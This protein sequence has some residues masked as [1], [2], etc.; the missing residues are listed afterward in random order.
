MRPA[1]GE[2]SA[3]LADL[4]RDLHQHPDLS[5]AETRTAAI[6]GARLKAAGFETT[7]RVGRTGVVGLLRNGDGPTALLRADMDALP[8]R[9]KTGL[10]YASD[11]RG[12]DHLGHEVDVFH[13]CGHDV[14]VTCLVGAARQLA[15]DRAAWAGTLMT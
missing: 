6:V 14:H 10:P 8:M 11:V 2:L 3:D 13:A 15:E 5:F 4:Y 12:V 1:A 9:E 7:D